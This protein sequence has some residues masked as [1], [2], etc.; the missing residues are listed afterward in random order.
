MFGGV[1]S[2]GAPL[3]GPRWRVRGHRSHLCEGLVRTIGGFGKMLDMYMVGL[4]EW[5]CLG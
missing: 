2:D 3:F 4:G 1:W 5:L